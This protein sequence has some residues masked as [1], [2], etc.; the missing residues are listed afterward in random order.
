MNELNEALKTI[1]TGKV[2]LKGNISSQFITAL[3]MLPQ[4]LIKVWR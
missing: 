2:S 3:M 4:F 1:K